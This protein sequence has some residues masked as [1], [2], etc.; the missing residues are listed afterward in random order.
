MSD[1]NPSSGL[2]D[3]D[4]QTALFLDLIAQQ[5]NM[6]F[7]LLGH[8]PNPQTGQITVDLEAARLFIDQLEMLQT[9]TKGNLN[10]VEEGRLKQALMAAR[11][12]FVETIQ[13]PPKAP[14]AT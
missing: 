10:S 13:S 9:K 7:L 4:R 11:M 3:G 12:A 8:T 1:S 14:P 2:A 5:A 6:A